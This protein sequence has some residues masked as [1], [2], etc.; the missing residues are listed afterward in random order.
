MNK[1]LKFHNVQVADD[2]PFMEGLIFNEGA[3]MGGTFGGDSFITGYWGV[4]VLLN[5]G[6]FANGYGGGNN[7]R[8]YESGWSAFTINSRTAGT[9]TTFDKRLVTIFPSG[10]SYFYGQMNVSSGDV[11]FI[12]CG[13]NTNGYYL[14][15]GT[16]SSSSATMYDSI[17]SGVWTSFTGALHLNPSTASNKTYINYY[18]TSA[19]LAVGGALGDAKLHVGTG[20]ASTGNIYQRYVSIVL[21]DGTATQTLSDVCAIFDSS[22]WCKSKITISSDERIKKNIQDINDDS[23]LQKILLIQPKTYEYIDKVEKGS[24][25]V[26]GF[27]AQQIKEVIPEAVK[28][29]KAVTPNILRVC[30]YNN[31]II[32]L[33][34][35]EINKLK[36]NDEIE[37]IIEDDNNKRLYKIIEIN[38]VD[39]TIKINESL[40]I[41]NTANKNK[42]EEIIEEAEKKKEDE[43][44]AEV[45]DE[46]INADETPK[47]C[48]IY[49]SKVDDFHTLDKSY[50][51]TLNVC[52]TQELYK[53]IQQQNIIIQDLQ[54]R[55]SILE[56][57]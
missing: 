19:N 37:I 39:N 33:P 6:G 34:D 40:N 10:S 35:Q 4:A 1:V 53:I 5:A 29:E 38:D 8:S 12:K 52:A 56:N 16:T 32:T 20:T 25:I 55:I 15:V 41:I 36:I 22:L 17:S 7:T 42:E 31:D 44:E 49:G 57:K 2:R 47:E 28:I 27:I 23:A 26:Y 18:N 24:D 3:M 45:M 46:I 48:F 11:S 51:Y 13:A 50:V 9:A 14:N 30:Q 54:N 21:G 43:S